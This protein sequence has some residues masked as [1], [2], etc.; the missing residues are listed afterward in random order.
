MQMRTRERQSSPSP[1]GV[2]NLA[3]WY[4][5]WPQIRKTP[6][7]NH[8]AAPGLAAP[9]I[10]QSLTPPSRKCP[11]SSPDVRC[12]DAPLFLIRREPKEIHRD[13]G[14]GRRGGCER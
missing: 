12:R 14:G 3:F 11:F 9:P 7:I 1:R 4:L 10:G 6:R 2:S 13:H 8:E 5:Q